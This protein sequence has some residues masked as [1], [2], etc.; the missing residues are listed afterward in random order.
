VTFRRLVIAA[1]IAVIG[2]G[3]A[4]G[5]S[6]WWMRS[7][8]DGHLYSAADVPQRPV[9]IVLGAGVDDRGKPTPFLE[10]RLELARQLYVTGKVRAILASGDN[11]QQDYNEVDP[12]REWLI[13]Q[14]IPAAKV[15]G[16]YAG[17]DTYSTCVRAKKIFGVSSAILVTQSF[18]L[19][20]AVALCRKM[21]IDAVGV[22]DRTMRGAYFWWHWGAARDRLACV[23]AVFDMTVDPGPKFLGPHETG[24]EDALR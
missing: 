18:H 9:A 24:V 22:G 21:G 8:A 6:V 13:A 23:K 11:G 2:A 17:F 3:V 7:L 16:D 20:R 12:M 10:A 14:G 1:L 19:A 15:V 4:V 5:G